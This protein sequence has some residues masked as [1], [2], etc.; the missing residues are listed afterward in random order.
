[1]LIQ[2]RLGAEGALAGET[3]VFELLRVVRLNLRRMEIK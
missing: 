2:D 3:P 1:M